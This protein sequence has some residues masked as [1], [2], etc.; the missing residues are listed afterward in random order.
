MI[1]TSPQSVPPELPGGQD[2]P[3]D[4]RQL[5]HVVALVL[6]DVLDSPDDPDLPNRLR[7]VIAVLER[8]LD[9]GGQ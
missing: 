2:S 8:V 9:D 1:P 6:H 7:A 5:L 3:P 4:L